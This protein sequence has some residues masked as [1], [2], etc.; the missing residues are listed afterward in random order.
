MMKYITLSNGRKMPAIVMSTNYMDYPLMK[1][2]VS[3]GLA[4][5]YR[6]FDTARDY[7]NEPIVGRVLA[8][9]LR[10]A[11]LTRED[12]F[13]TTKIGNGQQAR[14][15][16]ARE[17][18]ISLKNLRTDYVDLWLMH[19]P[20]PG[21][22]IDTYHQMEAVYH[23]GRARAIG[24]ANYRL[25][26]FR[27]LM[28]AGIEVMPHAVQHEC[29]PLRTADDILVF[30][31][32][33]GIAVQAYSALCRMI[34]PVREAEV[35]QS[36]AAKYHKTIGQIILR[37]HVERG[38]VPVFKSFKPARLAENFAIWDFALTADEVAAISAL[39]CDYKYHLE[40]ASCPGY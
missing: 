36:L 38:T 15:D 34:A 22:Y 14:G 13:I 6:A 2:V 39:D 18:D 8:E 23:S 31:R 20:Y 32:E 4:I 11:G 29:H 17:I 21:Y 1:Q 28:A 16:I 3:A 19:W 7:G 30:C 27:A 35:L 12:I 24:M 10:E 5:G 25:R 33:R 40:S 37:W 26:H 9:C